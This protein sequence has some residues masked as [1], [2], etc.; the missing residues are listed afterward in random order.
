M[1]EDYFIM[2]MKHLKKYKEIPSKIVKIPQNYL[3]Y[4]LQVV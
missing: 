3:L 1:F 2:N 4:S